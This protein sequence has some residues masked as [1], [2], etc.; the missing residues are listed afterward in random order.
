MRKSTFQKA[1]F[2]S[3]VLVESNLINQQGFHN[4]T[5]Q[6]G[7]DYTGITLLLPPQVC[8][9]NVTINS[10]EVGFRFAL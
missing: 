2:P 8:F 5:I 1:R 4:W 7:R 9:M 10:G 3:R 6:I